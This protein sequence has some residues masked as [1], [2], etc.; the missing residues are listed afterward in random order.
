MKRKKHLPKELSKQ[1]ECISY[2]KTV[3]RVS[4][5]GLPPFPY[6]FLFFFV[7]AA[8]IAWIWVMVYH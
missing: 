3:D 1:L 8:T 6:S 5:F 2:Q 7:L 4:G